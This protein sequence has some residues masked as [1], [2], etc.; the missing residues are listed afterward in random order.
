MY[1]GV[2]LGVSFIKFALFDEDTILSVKRVPAPTS[3]HQVGYL[4]ETDAELFFELVK[5]NL[6]DFAS[7][8]ESIKGILFSTQMHGVVLFNKQNRIASS[9]ISWKDRRSEHFYVGGGSA[10]EHLSKIIPLTS[11][12]KTGMPLRSGLPSVN[13]FVI[14]RQDSELAKN[15]TF[16]TIADYVVCKLTESDMATSL[17]NAAGTGLFNLEIN[18]W[19]YEL[20][21]LLG[22]EFDLPDVM[23]GLNQPIGQYK[24]VDVFSPIG[25]QQAALYGLEQNL[26]RKAVSNIATGSQATVVSSKL[27]MSSGFQTRPFIDDSYLFTIPFIPAG[28]VLNS[29]VVFFQSISNELFQENFSYDQIWNYFS[30]YINSIEENSSLD[31]EKEFLKVDTDLIGSFSSDGGSIKN[32]TEN[33]FHLNALVKAFLFDIVENHIKAIEQLKETGV[34]E[35]ILLSGGIPSKLNLIVRMFQLNQDLPVYLPEVKEDAL[36]GLRL[37]VKNKVRSW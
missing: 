30:K 1:I 11:L 22:L 14:N 2:D 18:D 25:D 12:K 23:Y 3:K 34:I 31:S 20:I 37:L 8:Y 19:N 28:R 21:E 24:G 9:Y 17:S 29:L 26:D 33:N 6:D 16:G 4:H 32:I 35:S 5:S 10:L 13:L 36:N 15:K 27:I 7:R